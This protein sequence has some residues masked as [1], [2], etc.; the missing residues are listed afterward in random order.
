MTTSKAV[1]FVWSYT[2]NLVGVVFVVDPKSSDGATWSGPAGI[3]V[4][5]SDV[6]DD[7]IG[8]QASFSGSPGF[9]ASQSIVAVVSLR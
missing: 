5:A 2:T 9:A 3:L 6:V 4:P 7:S 1:G 8:V